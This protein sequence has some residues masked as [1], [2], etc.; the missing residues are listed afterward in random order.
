MQTQSPLKADKDTS[1]GLIL[2]MLQYFFSKTEKQRMQKGL[3]CEAHVLCIIYSIWVAAVNGT[4]KSGLGCSP[5]PEQGVKPNPL[6]T[7]PLEKLWWCKA[8]EVY[9]YRLS[10]C[11]SVWWSHHPECVVTSL[12][13]CH[14]FQNG[15][16]IIR[17]DA[18]FKSNIL[19]NVV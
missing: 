4:V 8:K 10:A 14:F 18:S 17:K 19:L 1:P 7:E 11:L 2:E 16:G 3:I 5:G 9:V 13:C 6:V 15:L 12:T